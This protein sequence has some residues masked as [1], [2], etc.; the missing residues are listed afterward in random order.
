M[1]L[2]AKSTESISKLNKKISQLNDSMAVESDMPAEDEE[3]E[4]EIDD[5]QRIIKS[6]DPKT[7]C[8]RD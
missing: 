3:E 8:F 2:K 7:V 5:M 6:T 4:F 1:I